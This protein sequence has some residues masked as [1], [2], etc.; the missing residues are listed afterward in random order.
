MSALREEHSQINVILQQKLPA[1]KL[2][3]VCTV[4]K[5][6]VYIVGDLWLQLWLKSHYKTQDS[7]PYFSYHYYCL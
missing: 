2:S 7:I 4:Y 5:Q 1:A 3:A 6:W